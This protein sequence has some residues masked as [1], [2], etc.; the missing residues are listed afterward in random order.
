SNNPFIILTFTDVTPKMMMGEALKESEERF[1]RIVENIQS[2]ITIIENRKIVYINN[3]AS[4]IFGYPKEELLNMD[5][6]DLAAPEEKAKLKKIIEESINKNTFPRELEFWIVRKDGTRRFINN[7]YSFSHLDNQISGR[8]V[9]TTDITEKKQ[10]LDEMYRRDAILESVNFASQ[11]LLDSPSWKKCIMNILKRLGETAEVSRAYIFKNSKDAKGNILMTQ[12]YEWVAEGVTPQ[13]DTSFLKNTPYKKL[14]WNRW[15][16][17]FRKGNIVSGPI[18]DFPEIEKEHLTLQDIKSTLMAPIFVGA[19]W[20][21]FMG[22]D[23]CLNERY[24][25]HS[26]ISALEAAASI[27]GSSIQKEEI[28]SQLRQSKEKYQ[29]LVENVNS[30]IAKFDR[31]GVILS[32]NE[33]GLKFFEYTEQEII[34]K[35]WNKTILPKIESTGRSLENLASDIINNIDDY[36]LSINENIKKNGERVWVYWTNKPIFDS[37]GNIISILSVGN[38]ITDQRKMEKELERYRKNLEELVAKRTEELSNMNEMLRHEIE[39]REKMEKDMLRIEKLESLG[40]LAGG[41]AHDFNNLLSAIINNIS[42]AKLKLDPKDDTYQILNEAEIGCFQSKNLTQQLLTF[43]RGGKPVKKITN[44]NDIIRDTVSFTLRGSNINY[45]L[46]LPGKLWAVE[47]DEGQIIQAF[48]NIVLNAKESMLKGGKV[49]VHASNIEITKKDDL[50]LKEGKYVRI[51]ISDIG[52][53]IPKEIINKIFDPYFTTKKFGSGLGLST[54]YSIIKNHDGFID[55]SSELGKGTKFFIYLPATDKIVKPKEEKETIIKGKGRVLLMDDEQL[56]L[57]S[58]G[59]LLEHM[60]YEVGFSKDGKEA[61]ELYKKS[62]EE[63]KK[64]E[65]IIMDLTIA[66]GM[67][68]KDAIG[69]ILKLDPS[70]KVIVSSGYSD[71]PIMSDYEKY[72]FKGVLPKPYRMA[73]LA[74]LLKKVIEE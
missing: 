67:G 6:F 56:L 57:D 10:T 62:I 12:I 71:D 51:I 63:E 30:I 9:I 31:D 24:W 60:G 22:F 49:E 5:S 15:E 33:Y 18:K 50:P 32:M 48:S 53:G 3:K 8:Y 44:L 65:V 59:R 7:H 11:C 46:F 61:I 69:T 66:G 26:E 27:L 37:K 42:I 72:G 40:T 41:L 35:T 68:G 52:T 55:L 29:E 73:K 58:L 20:W 13:I 54:A 14:G 1:R 36:N 38:D 43:S 23:D 39:T 47:V 64:F 21:G 45:F 34:G 17:E 16:E 4:E 28:E 25:S 2:G 70:A 74:E 19:D